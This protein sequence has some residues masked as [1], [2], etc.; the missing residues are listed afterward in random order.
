MAFGLCN[1]NQM[2]QDPSI[3]GCPL[4]CAFIDMSGSS[5]L[6]ADVLKI[7]SPLWAPIKKSTLKSNVPL[8][9]VNLPNNVKSLK[10]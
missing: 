3:K 8:V 4:S 5:G 1:Y 9:T 6:N 2:Q 7:H 10:V